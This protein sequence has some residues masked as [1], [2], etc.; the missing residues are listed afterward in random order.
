MP[1]LAGRVLAV[2]EIDWVGIA[3]TMAVLFWIPTHILTFSIRYQ[4]DYTGAGIPTFPSRYGV[5]ATQRIIALSSILASIAMGIS[6]IGI[7]LTW[8]YLRVLIVLSA[9]LLLFAISSMVRPSTRI[10]FGLFK[11]ASLFML[12]SMLIFAVQ[13]L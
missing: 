1:V 10:N 6:A 3:L 13:A 12:G 4:N 7:G 8:G 2:G 11:Y 5:R 9:G